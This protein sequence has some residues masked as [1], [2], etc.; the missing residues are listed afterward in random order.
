MYTIAIVGQ[1][2]GTGKTTLAENLAVAATKA[3]LTVAVIDL[4]SQI[5]ATNWA[6]R[7]KTETPTVVSCQV[8]RLRFV[9][10]EARKNGV[11]MVFLDGPGKNAEATLEAAKAAD[12]VIIPIQPIIN[13]IET[14]PAFRDLLRVAG[15]KPA[16]V[17]VNNAPIQGSRH[18]HAQEA[19]EQA[20]FMVCP[21][22]LFRRAAVYDSPLPGLAVQEYEPDGKAAQEIAQLYKY[23]IA[24][25][26][27][28]TGTQ[29]EQT[30]AQQSGSRT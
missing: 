15:D 22:V 29:D 28:H 17:I 5:T 3:R 23:I 13:D 16:V 27:N 24:L 26:H 19:A 7:R 20:G 9:L 14:L 11:E 30:K 12:L 2:G 18:I 8:A 10:T 1:K 4:D 21:V 6:D 25:L